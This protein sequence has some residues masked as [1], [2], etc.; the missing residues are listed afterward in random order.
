M[1]PI[2]RIVYIGVKIIKG[3]EKSTKCYVE[4]TV[5]V[6]KKKYDFIHKSP[7]HSTGISGIFNDTIIRNTDTQTA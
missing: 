7:F 4:K 3:V 6:K 1:L 5:K 2:S